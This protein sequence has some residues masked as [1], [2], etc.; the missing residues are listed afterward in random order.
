[1]TKYVCVNIPQKL[2][3]NGHKCILINKVLLT[4]HFDKVLSIPCLHIDEQ[5]TRNDN[6]Q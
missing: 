6:S 5:E 4:F 3:K 1:M 2:L